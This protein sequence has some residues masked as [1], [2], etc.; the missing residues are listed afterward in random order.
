MRLTRSGHNI[1]YNILILWVWLKN[2]LI[3]TPDI[4]MHAILKCASKYQ[5][6][7]SAYFA[8]NYGMSLRGNMQLHDVP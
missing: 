7:M 1:L 4:A 8:H 2:R 3:C 5:Q 6:I